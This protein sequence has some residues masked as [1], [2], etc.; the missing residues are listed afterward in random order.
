MSKPVPLF[1]TGK[2][3]VHYLFQDGSVMAEEYDQKTNA[4]DSKLNL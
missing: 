4:L 3:K 2:M 1:S